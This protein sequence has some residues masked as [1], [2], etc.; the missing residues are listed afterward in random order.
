MKKFLIALII[1]VSFIGVESATVEAVEPYDVIRKEISYYHHGEKEIA[2]L[3]MAILYAA[4]QCQLDPLL[5][6]A[7]METESAF[8]FN[9]I[10]PAGAIGLMQLM[11]GTAS[12]IGIDPHKPLANIVGGAIYLK[13]QL[14]RFAG[15]GAYAISYALAAYNAG[16]QAVINANGI[17]K[18]A[19]TQ[20]YVVRVINN[21]NRLQQMLRG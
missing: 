15:N 8:R 11:P 19:E 2:W 9:A 10:S 14:N 5:I 12:M 7:V 6:T 4:E 21:Y 17:P 3:S 18:F 1:S 16:P 13:N 20:N